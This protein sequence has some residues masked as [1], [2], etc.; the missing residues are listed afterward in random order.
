MIL[1]LLRDRPLYSCEDLKNQLRDLHELFSGDPIPGI[2]KVEEF[3]VE[4]A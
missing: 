4:A 2:R 3:E 1:P